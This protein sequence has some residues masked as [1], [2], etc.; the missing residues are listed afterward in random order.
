MESITLIIQ[1][2][3]CEANRK[4]S[5]FECYWFR[6]PSKYNPAIERDTSNGL[7]WASEKS[8]LSTRGDIIRG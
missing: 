7:E 5:E 4:Q 3:R 1:T 2:C 8:H 6:K